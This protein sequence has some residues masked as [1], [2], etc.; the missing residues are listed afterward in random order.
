MKYIYTL[1]FNILVELLEKN[2]YNKALGDDALCF[3]WIYII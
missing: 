3:I 1:H 2:T